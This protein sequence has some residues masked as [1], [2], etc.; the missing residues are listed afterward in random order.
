MGALQ[1]PELVPYT[2]IGFDFPGCGGSP[3]PEHASYTMEDL[4]EITH[5]V[6]TALHIKKCVIIGHSMGGL[7]GLLFARKYPHNL[8]G[9]INVEGNLAPEDCFASRTISQQSLDDFEKKGFPRLIKDIRQSSNKGLQKIAK[10]LQEH[11]SPKALHDCSHSLVHY[12]DS[13]KLLEWFIQLTIPKIFMYGSENSHLS[14]IPVLR[15]QGVSVVEI[16]DSGHFPC[17]DNPEEY[18]G[19]VL[20]HLLEMK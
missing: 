19:Q 12:S 18:W 10:T 5:L 1:C 2:I 8:A 4:V 7:V 9:F 14:Y 11:T 16:K 13:G 15:Q 17:Y 20:T 3:Y 6:V